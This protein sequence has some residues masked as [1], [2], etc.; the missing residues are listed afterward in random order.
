MSLPSRSI[1]SPLL[2]AG[3]ALAAGAACA[4][5]AEADLVRMSQKW[6]DDTLA[7]QPVGGP[8]PLRLE[9]GV[10]ALDSRLQLAPCRHVEPYVPAGSRLWGRTRLGLRCTDGPVR[11]NVFIPVTVKAF[12]PGWV[13]NGN[14]NPGAVLNAGDASPAEV[15][16]AADN[17]AVFTDPGQ[18]TGQIAARAL[19]AG[20]ALRHAMVKA[21]ALFQAGAQVRLVAQ[22]GGFS[23]A[24]GGQAMG[25]GAAGQTVRVRIDNGRII[26]GTVLEDGTVQV[27]I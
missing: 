10:G 5:Q 21:P 16:W 9:V 11:W 2:A 20:Q 18:F 22:G 27:A 19:Q 6:I 3:L 4:Q 8:V 1:L 12:G 7:R 24:T 14:V 23:V 25:T 15:D 17:A 13:L 26:S